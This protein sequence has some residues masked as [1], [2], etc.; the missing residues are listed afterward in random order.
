MVR[1]VNGDALSIFIGTRCTALTSCCRVD[2]GRYQDFDRRLSTCVVD[3]AVGRDTGCT[4]ADD[5]IG[6]VGIACLVGANIQRVGDGGVGQR[7]TAAALRGRGGIA[8][9]GLSRNGWSEVGGN[10]HR[11]VD[12]GQRGRG[13]LSCIGDNHTGTLRVCALHVAVLRGHDAR[14]RQDGGQIAGCLSLHASEEGTADGSWCLIAV[15]YQRVERDDVCVVSLQAGG[16]ESRAACHGDSCATIHGNHWSNV[17]ECCS[18]AV[19]HRDSQLEHTVDI[20]GLGSCHAGTGSRCAILCRCGVAV[21][22]SIG[23]CEGGARR[24]VGGL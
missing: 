16:E 7:D 9:N 2:T 8:I 19:A 6:N 1:G 15:G 4:N 11:V 5:G 23:D 18:I 12:G 14:E 20:G 3:V 17:G 22:V 24:H 21:H 13:G 10:L